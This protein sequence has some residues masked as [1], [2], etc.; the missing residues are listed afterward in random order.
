MTKKETIALHQLIHNKHIVIKPA[1]KGSAVVIMDREQYTKEAHRQL[2]NKD[3]YRPLTRPIYTRTIPVIHR[4]IDNLKN[5][6]FIDE[7]QRQYLKGQGAPRPRRFYMLPKIHKEQQK[8]PV[9][10]LM[11]PGRPIV[12]DCESETYATAE[13]L[14]HYLHPFSTIHP[15]YIKD[16]YH[17]LDILKTHTF[18]IQS[19]LFTMDVEALYTNIDIKKGIRAVKEIFKKHPDINRPDKEIIKLLEVNLYRNDF[20]FDYKYYLQIKGTAMGKRFAPSYANIFMASW[21]R[22]A[23]AKTTLQPVFYCRYLDDIFAIWTHTKEEFDIFLNELNQHDPDIR[24]T[25]Q[26]DYTQINFLDT[27]IFKGPHF[28]NTGRLDSKIYFKTTDTHCLL[29]KHSFHPKHTYRGLIR[30]QLTRFFRICTY[31]SDLRQAT[32]ILFTTLRTRGYS[33]TFLRSCWKGFQN[34]KKN[35]NTQTCYSIHCEIFHYSN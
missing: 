14:E 30:S 26:I 9:P 8:W 20:E 15:A 31:N 5:K 25:A 7:L 10:G 34:N 35:K 2:Q 11:P 28:T 1:D 13:L 3:Y 29:H 4:M 18:P 23:L 12:S 24:L 6:G 19:F 32:R 22:E 27:V 17:F 33:K 21:E 16:T